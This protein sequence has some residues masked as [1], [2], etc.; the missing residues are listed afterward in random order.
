MEALK[1]LAIQHIALSPR[2]ALHVL[3]IDEP[4]LEAPRFQHL[5]QRYPIDPGRLHCHRRDPA[6]GEPVR[7]GVEI[8]REAAEPP[9]RM[10]IGLLRNR[11]PMLG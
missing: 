1:P 7:E 4:D 11:N 9:Y 8:F 6:L 2:H 5:E 10:V 3:G